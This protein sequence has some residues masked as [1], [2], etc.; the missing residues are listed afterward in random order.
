MEKMTLLLEVVTPAF[1]SGADQEDVELRTASIKGEL[2]WWWRALHAELAVNELRQREGALFGSTGM[3]LK[4]PLH[5]SLQLAGPLKVVPRRNPSPR[6]GVTYECKRQS[7]R[8]G[9]DVLPYLGYGPI[10]PLT[11]Q[12]RKKYERTR[13][14]RDGSKLWSRPLFIRPAI[15]PGTRF[16][17]RLSWRAGTLSAGQADEI[18]DVA[19]AWLA[20]GGVGSRSRKGFGS[21]A[22]VRGS[23]YRGGNG[24]QDDLLRRIETFRS[25]GSPLS[26][27]VPWWPSAVHRIVHRG[28][29]CDSW[30]EALGRIGLVY[31]ERRPKGPTRWIGGEATPRRASSIFLSVAALDPG[32]QGI[33]ALLPSTQ[34]GTDLGEEAIADFARE[35]AV[36]RV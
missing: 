12:E 25:S 17:L 29:A 28:P 6:S 14:L 35:F 31:K 5:L 16:E 30:Q 15:A 34:K 7:R 13:D 1:L 11:K 33:L 36:W 23:R 10:R 27:R 4:S 2:H 20:L 9:T 26:G 19:A 24:L 22:L 8:G 18:V 21:L 3:K 32:Y